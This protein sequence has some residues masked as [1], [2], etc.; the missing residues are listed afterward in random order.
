MFLALISGEGVMV[1]ALPE[2]W[3]FEISGG[4]YLLL[5]KNCLAKKDVGGSNEKVVKK[6]KGKSRH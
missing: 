6:I 2:K 5:A 1:G 4:G 3:H